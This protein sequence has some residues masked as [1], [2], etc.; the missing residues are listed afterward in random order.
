MASSD[1]KCRDAAKS[2]I[3]YLQ[4]NIRAVAKSANT[5]DAGTAAHPYN[6]GELT[7]AMANAIIVKVSTGKTPSVTIRESSSALPSGKQMLARKWERK[8][9]WRHPVYGTSRGGG[10]RGAWAAGI[11]PQPFYPQL[12]RSRGWFTFNMA[13]AMRETAAAMAN[14]VNAATQGSSQ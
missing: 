4:T 12:I 8:K 9:S 14:T 13:E 3:P 6:E 2:T 10:W 7:E 5:Q 11:T 1:K